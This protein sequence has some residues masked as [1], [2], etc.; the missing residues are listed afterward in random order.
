MAVAGA[1]RRREG[2]NKDRS[3][4]IL[5]FCKNKKKNKINNKEEFDPGSGGALATGLRHARRGAAERKACFSLPATGGRGCNTYATCPW[6]GDN[7][8]KSGLIPRNTLGGHPPGVK[9]SNS[10]QGWA[11]VALGSWRCNGPPNRRCVRVLRGRPP[12]L[13]LRHGPDSYGRQQ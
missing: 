12:T 9:G 10:G 8:E 7:P 5:L 4:G 13:V 3:L 2:K 1:A 6:Q 11:C